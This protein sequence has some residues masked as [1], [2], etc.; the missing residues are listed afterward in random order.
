MTNFE[1]GEATYRQT[2]PLWSIGYIHKGLE[3]ILFLKVAGCEMGK[4]DQ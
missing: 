4:K 2:K 1:A 3:K